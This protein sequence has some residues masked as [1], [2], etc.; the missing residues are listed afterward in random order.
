[1]SSSPPNPPAA[2]PDIAQ[3]QRELAAKTDLVQSIRKELIRSQIT[4]LELQ[5]S[6][7]KKET[8][9]A[10]AVSILGQAELVLEDK[11]N[12]IFELDRVLNAKIA[13][14]QRNLAAAEQAHAQDRQ[15][16][17]DIAND[18]AGKLDH[19]N[20]ELGAAHTLAGSYAREASDARNTL[21]STT[22]DL[23]NC[24][25]ELKK[26]L[27][28]LAAVQNEL[29][30]TRIRLQSTD[31]SRAALEHELTTIRNSLAW[32]ITAPLRAITRHKL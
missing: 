23:A 12:T 13:A 26:V 32:K 9:K 18:L 21:A 1:M 19:A 8:D 22:R 16:R 27:G 11:I 15:A 25:V 28:E 2:S 5:D 17:D 29:G 14:L 7:L 20:R 3:L 10:D 30:A 31:D 24:Q 4:V 6:I